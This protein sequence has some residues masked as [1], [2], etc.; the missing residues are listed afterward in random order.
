MSAEDKKAYLNKVKKA[1]TALGETLQG[2]NWEDAYQNANTLT[3]L[4]KEQPDDLTNG[5]KA[6]A[7]FEEIETQL[8]KYRY[9][10][11]QMRSAIGALKKKGDY[12]VEFA[13]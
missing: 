11:R 6:K 1:T 13:K 3:N 2:Q 12:F 8:E 5:E 10:N 4:L 9:F 7:N